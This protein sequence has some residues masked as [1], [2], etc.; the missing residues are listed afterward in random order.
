MI[1]TSHGPGAAAPAPLAVDLFSPVPLEDSGT[2]DDYYCLEAD[3][4]GAFRWARPNFRLRLDRPARYALL[5]VC[6]LGDRGWLRFASRGRVLDTVPL[7][8]G[9]QDCLARLGQPG[10]AGGLAPADVLEVTVGPAV[11]VPGDTRELGV[12]LRSILW[13]A[14]PPLV[15]SADAMVQDGYYPP[16]SDC[17]GQFRWTRGRFRLRAEHPARFMALRLCYP[18]SEGILRLSTP[19]GP[20]QQVTL[21]ANWE[22]IVLPLPPFGTPLTAEVQPLAV[23]PGETREL[24]VMLRPPRLFDD[25]RLYQ[26]LSTARDNALLN[27]AEFRAGMTRLQSLPPALRITTEVRCNLPETSQP[28]AYCA[29]DFA[30]QMERGS[31]AFRLETLT[32]LGGFYRAAKTFQDCS[33]GEPAM[34]KQ[35]GA[36]VATTDADGK[37][38]GLTS[39]GQLLVERRRRELLGKNITLYVSIDAAS[40]AGFARY[41]NDRFDDVIDNLRA[42]CRE[43]RAAGNKPRVV[44]SLIAMRSNLAELPEYFRLMADIGVDAV[45]LRSLFLDGLANR[46]VVMNNGYRFDYDAEILSPDELEVVTHTAERLAAEHQLDVHIQW[47]DFEAAPA[48][49]G[50]PLCSEPWKTMYVLQRG[51]MPCCFGNQPL[52]TFDQQGGRTLEQF[53]QDVFNGPELVHIRSELAA[54]R[55]PEYCRT[56]QNCPVTSRLGQRAVASPLLPIISLDESPAGA[57]AQPTCRSAA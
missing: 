12:A 33:I 54:G 29:W 27:E 53:L 5:R 4:E 47:R 31:P 52:A 39:N 32:E 7:G 1:A 9:W 18:G 15:V 56:C 28:C 22:E 6:Y 46:T 41:R 14:E 13:L 37:H 23:I 20:W 21:G 36:I 24:G 8:H 42:L 35:F 11:A 48:A 38:F 10:E 26:M 51:I 44:V 50:A 19:E 45:K 2:D 30:K 49:E 55:L 3:A 40:A 34:H 16:E 43:K 57:C 17:A 25:E